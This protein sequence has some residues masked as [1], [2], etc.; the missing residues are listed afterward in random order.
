[1]A[2]ETVRV[3][4]VDQQTPTPAPI[5]DVLV[6]VFDATGTTFITEDYTDAAGIADFT[7]DGDDPP[8]DY[9]IRLSKA[10][11][12]FDGSLG[13]DS[14]SPQ[15]IQVWTPAASSP[16]GTN[17]FT[18]RG[19]AFVHPTAVDHRMCRASGFF[20]RGDGEPYANLDIVF[21]PVFKPTLVDDRAVM[22]GM[23]QGRSDE[24][25]YFEIDLFRTGEYLVM[26]ETIE[27]CQREVVVPDQSSYNLVDLLFSV[28]GQV[29][30]APASL[31]L[32]VED[33]VDVVPTVTASDLRVLEGS[34]VG[35]VIYSIGDEGVATLAVQ[36][37]RL[38]ITA[39]AAGTTQI[40]V[41]RRDESIFL[42][43]E[44]DILYTPLTITV[45]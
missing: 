20:R 9:Q 6:R 39:L 1:M 29:V 45:S 5:E 18:V 22:G 28:V 15:L 4:V 10:V 36:N 32:A 13:D 23:I 3:F 43:P 21:T 7:L 37:D 11:I 31:T 40:D 19:K 41:E 35:D 25:G 24:D 17:D 30:F 16:S 34:A 14:K 42:I 27:D 12:A 38:V 33:V 26:L 2:S 8:V 44:S